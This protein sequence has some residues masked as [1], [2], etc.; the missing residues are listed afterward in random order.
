MPTQDTTRTS[1]VPVTGVGVVSAAG[2]S[3][4][5]LY[6]DLLAGARPVTVRDVPL[7]A[8]A[9]PAGPNWRPDQDSARDVE[10]AHVTAPLTLP[11]HVDA[12]AR[13]TIGRDTGLLLSAAQAALTTA[14]DAP[15]TA[16]PGQPPQA[17]PARA[18]AAR[19]VPA[20]SPPP[21]PVPLRGADPA[22]IG[23]LTGT[24]HAGRSEYVAI[25]NRAGAD[26][27]P[28]NPVWGPRSSYNAPGAALSI[29]LGLRGPN[30]TLTSGAAVGLDAIA[31][32]VQHVRTGRCDA[33][34]AG[35]VDSLSAACPPP[36]ADAAAEPA[37]A[38]AG[39]SAAP[40][41]E[42]A[43]VVVLTAPDGPVHAPAVAHV[44]ATARA[45]AAGGAGRPSGGPGETA[46]AN[47]EAVPGAPDLAEAGAEAARA[48][49]REAGRAAH[50]VAVAV[51]VA[52]PHTPA[53]A[54]ERAAVTAVFG[55]ALPHLTAAGT[56]GTTGGADGAL[57]FAVAVEALT[58]TTAPP[59][60]PPG[61]DS[62]TNTDTNTNTAP[63]AP[64]ALCLGL[65]PDGAATALLLTGATPTTTPTGATR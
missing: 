5:A 62:N 26:A 9:I 40:A 29:H 59:P 65:D 28:V 22:R 11:P 8:G 27:G 15:A 58:R 49:L 34:I 18:G 39:E 53:G 32:G 3:V 38:P 2:T 14:E 21:P 48:A 10:A 55:P 17:A 46:S 60:I 36:A 44:C 35:G 52:A 50:E 13:R 41:G 37:G 61:P 30:L 56:T 43:A 54:V 16:E 42:G 63:A 47:P 57:A 25:H 20:S 33:V 6:E 7:V 51:T 64:L 4:A 31:L 1:P 23:V 12:R 24:L 45:Y 19:P